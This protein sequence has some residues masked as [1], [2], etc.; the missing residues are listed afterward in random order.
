MAKEMFPSSYECDCGH[1]SDFF[2]DTVEEMKARSRRGKV[3]LGDGTDNEHT[4]VFR[5]GEATEIVCPRR[6]RCIIS[7]SE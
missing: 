1:E 4:I 6:G 2:E 5:G 7:E 3:E